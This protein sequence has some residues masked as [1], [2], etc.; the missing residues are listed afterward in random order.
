MPKGPLRRSVEN[1]A[2]TFGSDE[3]EKGWWDKIKERHQEFTSWEAQARDKNV[4][5]TK[6]EN[7]SLMFQYA[8]YILTGADTFSSRIRELS[9]PL[10][11]EDFSRKAADAI[12][13]IFEHP[14]ASEIVETMGAIIT[15]PVITLF[16]NY[17]AQDD[18][19]P[20]E[21]ARAFHG[22]MIGLNVTAGIADTT[23]EMITGGQVEGA[24]RMIESM[25][26]S[27]G[28][29][30]LGW[31]TLAPLL[32]SGLQ[33]PLERH[34]QKLYRNQ[35]FSA[36]EMRDLYALG[37]ISK[38]ALTEGAATEGWR[39][40]DIDQW[41]KLAF[42]TL[43]QGETFKAYNQG[44]MD[45]AEAIR[46][47]RSL[48]YDPKDIPLL[49]QL[50]PKSEIGEL[51]GFTAGTAR[52]AYREDLI[53]ETELRSILT[54]LNYQPREIDLI[55]SIENTRR[56][57]EV[58][59]LTL[60]QIKS[61][62]E[63]NVIV[64]AEAQHWLEQ[65]NFGSTEIGLILETWKA[66]IVPTFRKINIGTITGAYVEGIL[67]RNQ[68]AEKMRSVGFSNDDLAL[69][70]NLIEA[71]N[72]EAFGAQEPPPA[73]LLTPGTL[74]QLVA[75]ELITPSAMAIRLI[76]VGYTQADADLLSEA[77]RIRALPPERPLP[78]LSIERAY[79]AGIITREI[80]QAQLEIIGLSADDSAEILDT[81]EVENAETFGAP[82]E[83]RVRVLSP[84]ILEDLFISGLILQGEFT[85]RLVDL[86]F[87]AEDIALIIERAL[88]RAAPREMIFTQSTIE[89]AYLA[90]IFNRDE[91]HNYLAEHDLTPEQAETLLTLWEAEHPDIFDETP[92]KRVRFLS[93][94]VLEDLLL[95]GLI[96]PEFMHDRLLKLNYSPAD[97]D[98]LTQRAIQISA[99]A[100]RI[101]SK[102]DI[103]RAY[104]LGV[105][106][107][108]A[109]LG[110][111]ITMDF[112]PEDAEQIL[113]VLEAGN[114]Q[115][116]NPDLKQSTRLPSIEALMVAVR[117]GLITIDEYFQKARELG[118][119]PRDAEMYLAIATQNE[120][121]ATRIL[122]A[123]QVGQAYDA[124]LLSRGIS[125]TRLSQLGY[126]DEDAT[127]LLRIRKDFVINTD[128]WDQLLLGNLDAFDAISQLVNAH[129]ADQDIV[130]AFANLTPAR[131]AALNIDISNLSQ[132]LGEIPGGQ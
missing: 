15:E 65:A 117:N 34:Y 40:Q 38:Q 30:F 61:A 66:E 96:T 118:F 67:T 99:P 107:R 113:T 79:I 7:M 25:Y 124:G 88:L 84:A 60:G 5:E 93:A 101:L 127:L 92:D 29:G 16:E 109:A 74:A 75:V 71:R 22:F 82:P 76:Q 83:I 53:S 62:W 129:Y 77:A 111:L 110:K 98:L 126:G 120:R 54:D 12:A 37:E 52:Q 78:Q 47:L 9:K 51:R 95:G 23:L 11:T 21:F 105:I 112:E 6:T 59:S 91:V 4:V 81:V 68:A 115:V 35:R 49:F 13:K 125:L 32:G 102:E 17:A 3:G 70:L 26:W 108:A 72:P 89:R 58:K 18:P 69:E 10:E 123:S 41:I 24:G 114:P 103:T 73:K 46:R 106:D 63:E 97:A 90:G 20:H 116:F 8:L 122:N 104:L 55:V 128:T 36:S 45:E 42:R 43:N 100:I 27:L 31:Q 19:D 1:L 44:L 14:V 130:D 2:K 131:L 121:K 94:G 48:G 56:T 28:L 87:T 132:V 57:Q 50:H 80:A 85:D 33:P 64:D 119:E 86:G 39:A